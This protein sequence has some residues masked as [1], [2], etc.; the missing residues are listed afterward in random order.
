MVNNTLIIGNGACAI[1]TA[2]H[3]IQFGYP[4]ILAS[5]DE[6]LAS[7]DTDL[8]NSVQAGAGEILTASRLISCSGCTGAYHVSF[9]RDGQILQ[10]E[11]AYIVI[12]E[13]NDRRSNI[14]RYNLQP[15]ETII[16]LSV[17]TRQMTDRPKRFTRKQ[18]ALINSLIEENSADMFAEMIHTAIHLSTKADARVT[19]LTRNLKVAGDGLEAQYRDA[20]AA[21]V[22]FFKL[23][24]AH[25]LI[26]QKETGAVQ[27]DFQDELTGQDLTVSPDMTVVDQ[28]VEAS[29]YLVD[30]SRE[31]GLHHDPSG[32]LQ[33]GNIHRLPV[34]SNRRGIIVAGTARSAVT[35][36]GMDADAAAAA[37]AIVALQQK[38]PASSLPTAKI[39]TGSCVR[40]FTCLRLCP[41]KAVDKSTQMT[42]NQTACEGCGICVAECPRKA[43]RIE[44]PWMELEWT[45][46]KNHIVAFCCSRSAAMALASAT[47]S[48]QQLPAKL[49]IVE[50]PCAGCIS[51][52]HLLDA[53][54]RGASGVLV[55]GCHEGNCHSETGTT[56]CRIRVATLAQQLPALGI[57]HQRLSMKTLAAQMTHEAI[58]M[59][60]Q[61]AASLDHHKA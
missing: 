27:I 60:N 22:T 14:T 24:G 7:A 40:C 31:L 11:V 4:V 51:L 38:P 8:L 46:T 37:G 41:F 21:G 19:F 61:F 10:R 33:T 56:A 13:G 50:I 58:D 44:A 53:F 48:N 59:L 32:F 39:D 6:T 16:D 35:H 12:A 17:C 54:A 9:D 3:L 5:M 29:D 57:T 30:L 18:V 26:R 43:I 47:R 2:A 15:S 55:L 45:E 34:Y 49:Q 23:S 1:Q 28:T 20:K 36:T 42:V 25:W 52:Q